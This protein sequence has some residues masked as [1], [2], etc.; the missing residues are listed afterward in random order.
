VGAVKG[1]RNRK[2]IWGFGERILEIIE[3]EKKA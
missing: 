1:L 2:R 3:E